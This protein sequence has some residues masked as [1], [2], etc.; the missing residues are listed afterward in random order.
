VSDGTAGTEPAGSLR[1][2][3]ARAGAALLAIAH[4]RIELAS[5]EFQEERDRTLGHLVLLCVAVLFLAF[6]MLMASALVVVL[7]WDTHR[8]AALIGVT[9]LHAAIGACALWRLNES[10]RN[11]PPPFVATLSELKRD[12]EWLSNGLHDRAKP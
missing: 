3:M 8:I 5:I 10:R 11:S 12:G 9:L 4:T 7:F 1:R 6:A 2:A